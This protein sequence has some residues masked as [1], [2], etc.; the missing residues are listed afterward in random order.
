MLRSIFNVIAAAL[1]PKT[2][3]PRVGANYFKEKETPRLYF[4]PLLK[5]VFIFLGW[6][7]RKKVPE[8]PARN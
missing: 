6:S 4:Q 1:E 5:I 2:T 8:G 7:E 3:L